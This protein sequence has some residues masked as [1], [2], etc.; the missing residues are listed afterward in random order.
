MKK[1]MISLFTG[2]G[3]LDWGFHN[4]KNYDL[5]IAN[6]ILKPHL[7]TYADNHKI[8]L[9]D[10]G[11]YNDV[12]HFAVCGDIHELNVP[13]KTDIIM[14][15]PP[16]QDFSILRGD[17]NR[18]GFTVKRGKLYEQYLKIIKSS[19]PDVFVFENTGAY[20]MTEGISLFL[21]RDLPSVALLK[22]GKLEFVRD[23]YN[24]YLLNMPNY[25]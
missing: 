14:G 7:K 20:C 3:G 16:C 11:D 9:I 10:I 22:N 19:N 5:V 8:K 21:S 17:D 2:A 12:E 13:L 18:A 1:K 15:G 25:N 4:S 23:A 6:E 24:T